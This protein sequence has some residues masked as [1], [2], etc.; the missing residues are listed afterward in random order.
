M[1]VQDKDDMPGFP[2]LGM[3]V[4]A[5]SRPPDLA[6]RA[7]AAPPSSFLI[8]QTTVPSFAVMIVAYTCTASRRMLVMD[9]YLIVCDQR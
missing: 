6:G 3:P 4:P 1:N 2:C 8:Q 5:A 9:I 7:R